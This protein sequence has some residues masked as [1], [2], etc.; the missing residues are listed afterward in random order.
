MKVQGV[1]AV[2]ASAAGVSAA[3][4]AIRQGSVAQRS[5][6][7]RRK[8]ISYNPSYHNASMANIVT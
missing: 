5:A 3:P 7:P 2:I 8:L 1:I 4:G 6:P